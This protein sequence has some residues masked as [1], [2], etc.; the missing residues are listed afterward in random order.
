MIN[1]KIKK[2]LIVSKCNENTSATLKR[3]LELM[4]TGLFQSNS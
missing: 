2:N 3:P 1:T 4:I